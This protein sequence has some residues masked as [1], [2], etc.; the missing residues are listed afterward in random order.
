MDGDERGLGEVD[1][2]AGGTRKLEQSTARTSELP[3]IGAQGEEGVIRVLDNRAGE[4]VHSGMQKTSRPRGVTQQALQDVRHDVKQV[5]GQGV[6]L[7]KPAFAA[8]PTSGDVDK[9]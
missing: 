6:T 3:L 8:D 7:P 9:S 4:I 5:G 1:V 2:Q